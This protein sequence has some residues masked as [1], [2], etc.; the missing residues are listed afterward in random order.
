M[1][2]HIMML[3][4]S[5]LREHIVH[6]NVASNARACIL[7]KFS[8]SRFTR[9][10]KVQDDAAFRNLKPEPADLTSR[11][12]NISFQDQ[13]PSKNDAHSAI[14]FAAASLYKQVTVSR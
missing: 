13:H 3:M 7:C 9:V 1:Q 4:S 11:P 5:Y 2:C 12:S 6:E 8:L 14:W 10:L